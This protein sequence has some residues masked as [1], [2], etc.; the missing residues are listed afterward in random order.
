LMAKEFEYDT[1]LKQMEVDAQKQKEKQIED[2][3]DKRT[4]LQ[5]TQQ[6]KMI[7]QRQDDLPPT[8]FDGGGMSIPQ[9]S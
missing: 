7:Q 9:L 6:S 2:R 8:D 3:K 4:E 5:A 1:K